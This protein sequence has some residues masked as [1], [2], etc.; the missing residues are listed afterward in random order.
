MY[1]IVT[2][3]KKILRNIS[4]ST[5]TACFVIPSIQA[6]DLSINIYDIQKKIEQ[7]GSAGV[8]VQMKTQE[9][10]FSNVQKNKTSENISEFLRYSKLIISNAFNST[11]TSLDSSK[12]KIEKEFS[13]FPLFLTTV[14][15]NQLNLVLKNPNISNVFLN[16]RLKHL[17]MPLKTIL[18]NR[19]LVRE[20]KTILIE[21]NLEKKESELNELSKPQLNKTTQYI[22]ADAL[23][24]EG[25]DGS[26]QVIV[27][28]D[29]GIDSQHDMFAGK[30][31]DEACFSEKVETTDE[32]LCGNG[33]ITQIGVGAASNCRNIADACDHG[34]HVAGIAAGNDRNGTVVKGVAYASKL[35][36]IQVFTAVNDREECDGQEKCIRSYLSSIL[37]GLNHVV[38]LAEKYNIASVNMS[39]GGTELFQDHCDDDFRK[40]TIDTLLSLDIATVIAAGN[41]GAVGAI[42]APGCVSSAVTVSSSIISVPDDQVNHSANV[43]LLAPGVQIRSASF[44]NN[45]AVLSGTSMATPH[46]SGAFALLRSADPQASVADIENALKAGGT[47]VDS[48]GWNWKTPLI[49]L[50]ESL[51]VLRNRSGLNGTIV[52]SVYGTENSKAESYVRFYNPTQIN[53]TVFIQVVNNLNSNN[54]GIIEQKVAANASIQLS[55]RDIEKKLNELYEQ[56]EL[57]LTPAEN[58]LYTLYVAATFKGYTQHVLYNPIG[59]SLTN[60]SGCK[61][62]YA[63]SVNELSNV[64]TSLI[65]DF[66]S[67]IYAHNSSSSDQKPKFNVYDSED[68]ILIGKFTID[69]SIPANTTAIIYVSDVIELLEDKPPSS[70]QLH[71]NITMDSE[72]LGFAQHIVDNTKAGILTNLTAKCSL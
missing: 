26:N 47:P 61:D 14:N 53:G 23:W 67:Y 37:S 4:F 38:D 36:P 35:I 68:G 46:V 54:L 48:T 2:V 22:N 65:R 5:L 72:F 39:I 21:K 32:S 42:N 55:M 50:S 20:N 25:I 9:P 17:E 33:A 1:V 43:D 11:K 29:D 31:L 66:P 62:G 60:L 57:S 24:D 13:N 30:I 58:Q 71:V 12:I 52:I 41:N 64:H 18:S 69:T 51:S 49:N 6:A 19:E 27:I 63:N 3:V 15:K 70:G 34:S 44:G 8:I 45:Y 16:K 7:S 10:L 56:D 59:G 28:I 40:S